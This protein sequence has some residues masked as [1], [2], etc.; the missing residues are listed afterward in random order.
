MSEVTEK[1]LNVEKAQLR[2]RAIGQIAKAAKVLQS[3][4]MKTGTTENAKGITLTVSFPVEPVATRTAEGK[5]AK[6][7][8]V[9]KPP[10][11]KK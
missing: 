6:P 4:G 10:R 2:E 1:V 7:V 11:R 5:D 9:E 3:S 8:K